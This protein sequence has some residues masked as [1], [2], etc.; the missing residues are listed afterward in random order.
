MIDIILGVI[1]LVLVVAFILLIFRSMDGRGSTVDRMKQAVGGTVML[2]VALM[3]VF[4]FVGGGG[5]GPQPP[6]PPEPG[7]SYDVHFYVASD[8]IGYG[9]V[10][11]SSLQEVPEG[12]AV[13]VA[14]TI[15]VGGL[16]QCAATP[17]A[18]TAQYEYA[19]SHWTG[20][21][22]ASTSAPTSIDAD[23]AYYAH[24]T[25][26]E[27]GPQP[28]DPSLFTFTVADGEATVTG[29]AGTPPGDGYDLYFPVTDGQG[30]PV[31]A[32]ADV[33]NGVVSPW[34]NAASVRGDTIETVGGRAFNN[35]AML[36]TVSLPV[37]TSIG[38]SAFRECS[39]MTSLN[40]P[41]LTDISGYAFWN[42][43]GLTSIDFPRLDSARDK[44]FNGCSGLTR[45][46][47]GPLTGTIYSD[48]FQSLT[49]YDTDGTTVLSPTAANL[50]NSTFEG[51]AS[52]L[53][54][55]PAGQ[56]S[57]S[58]EMHQRALELAE[59]TQHKIEMLAYID[60]A[61]AEMDPSEVAKMTFPEIRAL[62]AEDIEDI[63][64]SIADAKDSKGE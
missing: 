8:S 43:S 23:T 41:L 37:A 34:V 62:T 2:L 4:A 16:G 1:P 6:D 12:T 26:T 35:A 19:F 7:E 58:S 59:E 28:M 54:K 49:F 18:D 55:V 64:R 46:T 24:F 45:V 36:E 56:Q 27:V 38:M 39:Q 11:I 48:T 9:T 50:A 57:L 63:K 21:D 22:D 61:L 25:R 14:Q 40:S 17:S 13:T 47:L 52:A 5:D 10:S 51:T 30:H 31:T 42:C 15:S 53:I 60:P 44:V 33:G 32:I 3:V 20:A 29:W